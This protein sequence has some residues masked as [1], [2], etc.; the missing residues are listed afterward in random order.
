MRD[1]KAAD[2]RE[3]ELVGW[4]MPVDPDAWLA[5]PCGV[6]VGCDEE[7]LAA[8]YVRFRSN[9]LLNELLQPRAALDLWDQYHQRDRL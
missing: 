9:G 5:D 1:A 2:E 6:D 7:G 8:R 3:V 4:R